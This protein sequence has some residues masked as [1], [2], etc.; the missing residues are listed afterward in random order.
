MM[1]KLSFCPW[2][3]STD[4]E[5]RVEPPP[6]WHPFFK[7]TDGGHV[8]EVGCGYCG[9]VVKIGYSA[10]GISKEDVIK[11]AI[12]TYNRRFDSGKNKEDP[13]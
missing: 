4:L 10:K 8:A 2:C 9:L 11:D 13:E 6:E 3:G 5:L 7:N 12:E 1:K